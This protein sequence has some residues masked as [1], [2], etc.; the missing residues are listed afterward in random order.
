MELLKEP[1]FWEWVGLLVLAAAFFYKR[2]PAFI[3]ATL[4]KRAAQIS[5]QLSEA[6]TLR[7]EAEAILVEYRD[8]AR[9]AETE[10]ANIL[11]ETKAEAARFAA[12]SQA[13]LQTQIERR[14]RI[15]QERIAQAEAQALAEIRAVA[16]DAAVS[17]AGKLIAARLDNTGAGALIDQSIKGVA[18]KLN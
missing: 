10:A 2:V 8:K 3:G 17:A 5:Q 4:D 1:D 13:A 16:A 11:N 6:K 14:G 9:H 7:E 12:E 15:A 18:A